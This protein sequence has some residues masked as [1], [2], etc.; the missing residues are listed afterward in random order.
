MK[1]LTS[2]MVSALALSAVTGTYAAEASKAV[3]NRDYTDTVSPP[4]QQA[5]E[6]GVK[7]YN[8]CLRDHGSKYAWTAWAHETGDVYSYSYVI[9]PYTWEDFDAMRDV[10]KACDATWRAQGNPH[11]KGETSA[12]IVDQPEMSH[13]ARDWAKQAPPEL[14]DVVYFTLKPGHEVHEAF[15]TTA[16]KL[17]AAADK[18][19][20]PYDYRFLE[21]QGAGDDA[22]DYVLVSPNKN[23]AEYG[24]EA[25][26]TFWKMVEGVYGKAEADALRKSINDATAKM[27]EHVDSYNPDL[28][29]I[30]GH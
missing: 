1:I 6:A 22:P 29:Y 9:G 10:S 21:L 30:P 4:D 8:Q 11:L 16:K 24:T 28:S 7:A 15:T 5:Y 2:C 17:A 20:W 23:W 27:S 26:P 18:A 19:K 3:V 25:N 13:M 12:F 14:I